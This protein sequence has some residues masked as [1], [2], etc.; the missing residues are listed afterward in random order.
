MNTIIAGLVLDGGDEPIIAR[1]M[2]LA[3]QHRARLILVHVI[4]NMALADAMTID[5]VSADSVKAMLE[6]EA[7]DCLDAIAARTAPGISHESRVAEG[8]PF[9]VI[10]GLLRREKAD[11]VIIGP[12]K[13]RNL[14]EKVFGST[15][16]RIVRSA[17]V[18]VLIVR[19]ERA[20]PYRRVVVATD[21]SP[22]SL[23]ASRAARLLA[24]EA[25]MEHVHVVEIPLSFEQALLQSGTS[26]AEIDRY[27]RARRD[28]AR[29]RLQ[30]AFADTSGGAPLKLR[31]IH[32]DARDIIVRQARSRRTDLIALGTHGRDMA[33]Q[34][35][36]GSVAR[37]V[38]QSASCDVLI[39]SQ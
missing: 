1:A 14:R 6:Q 10:A 4:E 36:L 9:E 27:R 8:K 22:P 29:E 37:N 12:G 15:A 21:P 33:S 18:P 28:A 17:P 5:G 24:P 32:G 11:L 30:A 39:A 35:L 3:A 2:Q 25:A 31:I 38:L 20:E 7:A 16:D 26:A 34:M 13:P 19:S 23:S